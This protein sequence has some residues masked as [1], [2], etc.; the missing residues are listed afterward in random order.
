[1]SNYEIEGFTKKGNLTHRLSEGIEATKSKSKKQELLEKRAEYAK[2]YIHLDP[3]CIRAKQLRK[4]F[5]D[6]SFA[7]P[8][9]YSDLD[10][11][12]SAPK[13]NT[14]VKL[15]SDAIIGSGDNKYL[16]SSGAIPPLKEIAFNMIAMQKQTNISKFVT[17][18]ALN[19]VSYD[20]IIADN[21]MKAAENGSN[22]VMYITFGK[23]EIDNHNE[24]FTVVRD[25]LY[26]I[27]YHKLIKENVNRL[28][29]SSSV[30]KKGDYGHSEATNNIYRKSLMSKLT[31]NVTNNGIFV[32]RLRD[33]LFF[34]LCKFGLT[35]K[36][37]NL[38]RNCS[39]NQICKCFIIGSENAMK[40]CRQKFEGFVALRYVSKDSGS[41]K[42]YTI[43]DDLK[44]DETKDPYKQNPFKIA[45]MMNQ[46]QVLRDNTECVEIKAKSF[47][48]LFLPNKEDLINYLTEWNKLQEF[49]EE[50]NTPHK[51]GVFLY[52]APGTGKTSI[53]KATCKL[54][55]RGLLVG[56]LDNLDKT[57]RTI[58][59]IQNIE[60]YIIL[61][62]DVDLV[63]GSNAKNVSEN[64]RQT[65]VNKL[66]QLL[67]GTNSRN[68]LIF[69]T[70]N[71]K[72]AL[73][74]NFLRS[75]RFDI[76]LNI[77][78]MPKEYARM[79]ASSYDVDVT[80]VLPKAEVKED[81]KV[82]YNP[83]TLQA[84]CTEYIIRSKEQ[85]LKEN[86]LVVSSKSSSK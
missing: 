8:T 35:D 70:T 85:G 23:D 77:G 52:G 78:N 62:E 6:N 21:L 67:D 83:S 41:I 11:E 2:E 69:A 13:K 73:P 50:H 59:E 56:N 46:S 22:K 28:A 82:L 36:Y 39:D 40:L 4:W 9:E 81:G 31:L 64:D 27:K 47:D 86:A 71:D 10:K 20:K 45:G 15:F 58:A 25:F 55:G 60:D 18:I 51:L 80:K 84:A 44:S 79:L 72:T 38:S 32:D 30:E 76:K 61:F 43:K 57:L 29:S 74:E 26:D 65:K 5:R 14:L 75:G 48:D 19:K 66:L 34:V 17:G 68:T 1:M 24:V 33:D 63:I 16:S 54:L 7:L 12:F 53:V 49:Y 37:I 42:V 3:G